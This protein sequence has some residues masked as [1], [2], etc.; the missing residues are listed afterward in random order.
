MMLLDAIEFATIRHAGQMRNRKS[1]PPIPY[2][3]HPIGVANILVDIGVRADSD[4]IVAAILHDVVE[5]TDTTIAEIEE[6]FGARVAKLVAEVTDPPGLSKRAAHEYQVTR[7]AGMSLD[8]RYLKLADKLYNVRDLRDA[9][10]DWS[11]DSRRGYLENCIRV[12]HAMFTVQ[13]GADALGLLDRFYQEA[14]LTR[15]SV[16]A[17]ATHIG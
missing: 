8:A 14:A 17:E 9:P 15:E 12:V 6:R 1:G 7:A 3:V 16:R 10:P 4:L 11:L 13:N 5:D 2:I